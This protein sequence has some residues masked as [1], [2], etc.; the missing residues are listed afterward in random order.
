MNRV[1]LMGFVLLANVVN[2][3]TQIT[4]P[5]IRANFGVDADLRSNYFNGF[6]QSGNDDWFVLPGSLGTGQYVIDSTGAAALVNRYAT[7]IPFRRSTFVRT[8]R[9]PVYST[10]NNRLLL[11]AAFVRDF[12]GDDSTVFASGASKNGDNPKDWSTPVSQGI[13]D[14]NDILDM[15]I[16]IRRAGPNFNDSLWMFGGMSLD[17]TTGDRYFDFEMYQTDLAYDRANLKF[18]GYGPDAGHTSW[19]FD[20]AGN[21]I[22]AGDI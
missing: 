16:H 6:V 7:D 14:K 22:K 18:I 4:T 9:F 2:G 12:H 21:I 1:L 19:E 5:V 13:P 3:F 10:V 17:N 8:M 20:A 11:D 15:M